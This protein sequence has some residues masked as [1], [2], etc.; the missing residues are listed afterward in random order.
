MLETVGAEFVAHVAIIADAPR[1]AVE[2]FVAVRALLQVP[3]TK[4]SELLSITCVPVWISR[5]TLA[6]I[7]PTPRAGVRSYSR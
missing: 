2:R 3:F 5:S 6:K 4:Q 1:L 7:R